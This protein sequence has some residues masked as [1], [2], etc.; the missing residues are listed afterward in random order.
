M[1]TEAKLAAF[2]GEK[3]EIRILNVDSAKKLI[4]KKIKAYQEGYADQ[5]WV[6]TFEVVAITNEFE[7]ARKTPYENNNFEN[8]AAFWESYMT[9]EQIS[10]R[11]NRFLLIV[12]SDHPL[13][14]KIGWFPCDEGFGYRVYFSE[15]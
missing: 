8:L 6:D 13:T 5:E 10:D 7:I 12:N 9:E 2:F 14:K 4:G 11:K 15:K 3:S 1:K